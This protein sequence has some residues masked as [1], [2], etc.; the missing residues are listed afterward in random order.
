MSLRG[1]RFINATTQEALALTLERQGMH[2][3][4]EASLDAAIAA[5]MEHGLG[6]V[7]CTLSAITTRA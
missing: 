7:L 1:S 3:V 5:T 2:R 6:G 4:A